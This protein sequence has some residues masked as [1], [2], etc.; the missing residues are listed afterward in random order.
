MFQRN[1]KLSNFPILSVCFL[2]NFF[3]QS[4]HKIS[5]CSLPLGQILKLFTINFQ[6]EIFLIKI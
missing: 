5:I 2:Q 1:F 6:T 3:F 4:E